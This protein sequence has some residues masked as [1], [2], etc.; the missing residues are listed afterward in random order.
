MYMS[1]RKI[2]FVDDK[3]KKIDD[4]YD[5][6]KNVDDKLRKSREKSKEKLND[7]NIFHL[8]NV[9]TKVV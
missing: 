6:S 9:S 2:N 4:K 3:S 1:R 8:P 7:G 5:K